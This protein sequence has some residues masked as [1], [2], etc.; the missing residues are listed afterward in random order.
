[1]KDY[2]KK[3]FYNKFKHKD[4]IIYFSPGRV[5]LIG[6][7]TDYNGGHVFPA[8][9]SIGNYGI[10]KK[11]DDALVKIYSESYSKNIISFDL[12][13]F[14]KSLR[15]KW[16]NYIKGVFY[17][18]NQENIVIPYGFDLYIKTNLPSGSG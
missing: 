3:Q 17:V 2:L 15:N 9:I 6:E 16:L 18:F 1:M 5:N 7:H 13:N 10:V 12:N 11:R 8:A 14:T 4:G